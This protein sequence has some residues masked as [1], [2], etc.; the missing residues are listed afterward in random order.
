[1]DENRINYTF[2]LRALDGNLKSQI[3]TIEIEVK[4]VF[5]E[6]LWFYMVSSLLAISLMYYYFKRK[7]KEL[8]ERQQLKIDKQQKEVE[9][10]FLKLES[11]RSQMNPHFIFNAL[12]SI[13]DYIVL[14]K[15]DL[16]SAQMP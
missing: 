6:Q 5:Y 10:T 12:N 7:N 15:K 8:K 16:A 1:M 2:E 13:Q 11:L 4:G 3:K 14:N 9:N